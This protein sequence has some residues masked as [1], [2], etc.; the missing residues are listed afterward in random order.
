MLDYSE[1]KSQVDGLIS[2]KKYVECATLINSQL[3][4]LEDSQKIELLYSL[5]HCFEQIE[6]YEK[7]SKAKIDLGL[8]L[9]KIKNFDDAI[10]VLDSIQKAP[11]NEYYARAQFNL[12]LIHKSNGN[13]DKAIEAYLAVE[14]EDSKEYFAKARFNLGLI[15]KEKKELDKAIETYLSIQREDSKEHYAKAR[16]NLS[17]I[18][19]GHGDINK[20]IETY[21][22]IEREDSREQYAKARNNLGL[23]YKENRA[24]KKA[25][26][27]FLSVERE[28]SKEFYAKTR[29]N[30]GRLYKEKKDNE[31]AIESF[32]CINE[33]DSKEQYARSLFNLGLIYKENGSIDKAIETYLAIKKED[34]KK[35]FSLSQFN[36]GLI[37]INNKSI[38]KATE[39]FLSI[40]REDSKELYAEAR[41]RLGR[42][43]KE[44]KE[45]DKA[46]ESFL[47]IKKMDSKEQY[48]RALFNLGFI[49]KENKD[50]Q[51]SIEAYQ[52][53]K[54]ADSKEYFAIARF[55]L[56]LLFHEQKE[57][58]KATETYLSIN[59]EDGHEQYAKARNNLGIIYHEN[60]KLDE[61]I[62]TFLSVQRADD[63]ES[64]AKARNNLGLI[65]KENKNVDEAI[66]VFLTIEREDSK[67]LYAIAQ[68]KLFDLYKKDQEST[69]LDVMENIKVNDSPEYFALSRLE[70]TNF[71]L[72]KNDIQNAIQHLEKIKKE[73]SYKIYHQAIYKHDI[74]KKINGRTEEIKLLTLYKATEEIKK[75]L[76]IKN[77][78]ESLISH[79]TTPNVAKVLIADNTCNFKNFSHLRLNTTDR[80]NDPKEGILLH[81]LLGIDHHLNSKNY[82]SF[83][84]C[85]TFHHDSLNQFRLYGKDS[86]KEASGVSLVISNDYFN[87]E[88]TD[89]NIRVTTNTESSNE[90][91]SQN[92]ELNI[93]NQID[94][95]TSTSLKGNE[96]FP[97]LDSKLSLY[98]CIYFDPDSE[99][100]K[101][102][103]REEWTFCR[104]EKAR[105]SQD[106]C[107]YYKGIRDIETKCQIKLDEIK[108]IITSVYSKNKDDHEMIEVISEI[109]L[110][111]RYLI[112]HMAFKEEQECRIV[113]ITQWD[114]PNVQYDEESQ[115]FYLNYEHD[116]VKYLKKIYLAPFAAKERNFFEYI[117]T[118]AKTKNRT[119]NEV[120]IKNSHNPFR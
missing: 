57:E 104:Q 38:D 102:S 99:L 69:A 78:A 31:K 42:L 35:Y 7:V 90:M 67:E 100:L 49:Y 95:S 40:K 74:L 120:R 84:G 50:F 17:L 45:F 36:L 52:A 103:H 92:Q 111:L 108:E 32:L 10:T 41:N 60:E 2:Q 39:A 63:K 118:D 24:F 87:L 88:Y 72:N 114:D 25:I 14:K 119:E 77:S 62:E 117:T 110:P 106:W 58:K 27:I 21:L 15:Y 11:N 113:Y 54:R 96:E 33:T 34:S 91:E 68:L 51:K 112:K 94:K 55:N 30:L 65:Y 85:F 19:D 98:R 71:Y 79:Y 97:T 28:D 101:V 3:S 6:D 105:E 1:L 46:I 83:I 26:E 70:L 89:N 64:Y 76:F 81:E 13:F 73:H 22:S 47:T 82:K 86:S 115:R 75:N 109:L 93:I 43:Y 48:A 61:A 12:G 37:Y 116:M 4:Q 80:M 9:K 53:I 20:T 56:G 18:Y 5:I 29:I 107:E 16:F 44:N 66:K 8:L 59:R 23:L